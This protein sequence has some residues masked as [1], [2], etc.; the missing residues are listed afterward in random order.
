MSTF[1][2]DISFMVF[3][4]LAFTTYVIITILMIED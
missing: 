1:P 4:L 3:L 2:W